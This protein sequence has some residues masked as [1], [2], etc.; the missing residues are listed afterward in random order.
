MTHTATHNNRAKNAEAANRFPYAEGYPRRKSG[1]AT[2][3]SALFQP[4]QRL[5]FDAPLKL[6]AAGSA[7]IFYLV[8]VRLQA[9]HDGNKFGRQLAVRAKNYLIHGSDLP[10]ARWQLEKI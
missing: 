4:I 1:N 10:R 2:S 9:R 7:A 6:L 3:A 8:N 5:C